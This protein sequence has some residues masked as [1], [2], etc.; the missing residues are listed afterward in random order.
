MLTMQM[1]QPGCLIEIALNI[2]ERY[3]QLITIACLVKKLYKR[4]KKKKAFTSA[5]LKRKI[6][7]IVAVLCKF[8]ELVL[9]VFCNF[10]TYA[11]TSKQKIMHF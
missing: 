6:G 1:Q 5:L 9:K 3:P 2:E 4:S 11:V 7:N 8:V 10:N